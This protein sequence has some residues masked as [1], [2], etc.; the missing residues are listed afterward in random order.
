MTVAVFGNSMKTN[1][2]DEVG[3][4]L[5]F[6]LRRGVDIRLSQELRQELNLRDYAPFPEEWVLDNGEWRPVQGE[7][8]DFALSIG[9]DGTFLTTAAAIGDKNIPIIGVNMG[10]LGFL[11]DV[12]TKN[13]DLIMEQL[14]A[15][16]YTIEQRTLL[17]VS[18]SEGGHITYPFALN[19][20][21]V[22]KQGLSSMITV[23]AKLN[24][25]E[26]INM[27]ADGLV[28]STATGSTAYNLSVGGPI[29]VPQAR[30]VILAP[31]SSHSLSVRPLVIPDDWK[32]DL[33]VYSRNASYMLSIDGRSQII[34]DE[35][36]V[37]IEKAPHTIK[38]VQV[39]EN[40]F[41]NSL[42]SKMLWGVN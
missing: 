26:V 9:G 7:P 31:V 5:D 37:H 16:K 14:V 35:V 24:G 17:Q 39:G 6:L 27:E 28:I 22:L 3:H 29:M 25:E 10:H 2:S 23:L 36:T 30:S 13:V 1:M 42:K 32:I 38:V 34:S 40:S 8:I 20:V 15:G 21:A 18:C 11:A 19:E 12:Q 41:M 33:K 4:V